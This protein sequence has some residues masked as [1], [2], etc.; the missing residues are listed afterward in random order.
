MSS[1]KTFSKPFLAAIFCA[2]LLQ[3]CTNSELSGEISDL[4]T[5]T[6]EFLDAGQA[7]SVLISENS[8][9]AKNF[10]FDAGKD[11]SGIWDS[12]QSRKIS[13]LNWAMA[14]HWHRD[15]A[16]GFLEW[17]GS[18]Q[19]DTLFYGPDPE[20][21]WLRDSVLKLAEKF[22]SISVQISRGRR[23]S[24]G[25]WRCQI[26]WPTDYG[27]WNGNNAS[28]VLSISDDSIQALFAGDLEREGEKN[29]LGIS[30]SLQ[31]ELLQIGHHGSKNSSSLR[32][33]ESIFPHYAVISVGRQNSYGH[34][35]A[36]TL[37][38]LK[39]V[40]GDS[41]QI[42]RT[43]RLGSIRFDWKFNKGLWPRNF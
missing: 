13:H 28:L 16:G 5:A 7:L 24:C 35:A 14:S 34:P 10:L 41:C 6:M 3:S 2:S 1:F 33:L 43:D 20:N 39:L 11:S 21:A 32:F 23:P 40:L 38:R 36:E 27:S 15:H 30:E 29:L 26:L 42:F 4:D 12:L 37:E 18:V 31:A 9:E 19:I 25:K 22:G 17:D 8:G